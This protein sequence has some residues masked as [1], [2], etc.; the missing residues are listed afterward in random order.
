MK[1]DR[2]LCSVCNKP[3]SIF[4]CRGCQKDF[5]TVHAKEHRQDLSKQ[6]DGIVLE[7]DQLKQNLAQYREKSDQHPLMQKIDQWE[8]ESLEKIRKVAEDARKRLRDAITGH[9]TKITEDVKALTQDLTTARSEDSFIEI[10]LKSW[11]EKLEK[12]TKDLLTPSS[13]NVQEEISDTPFIQKLVVMTSESEFFERSAGKVKINDN[14]QVVIAEAG[15]ASTVRCRGEYSLGQHQFR[16]QLEQKSAS[17]WMFFGI[18]S[19]NTPMQEISYTT[20]TTFG[21]ITNNYVIRCDPG[22]KGYNGYQS[23][24]EQNDTIELSID[25]NRHTISL[26]NI[27]TNKKHELDV[28]LTKCPFP[29]QLHFGLHYENDR[30]RCLKS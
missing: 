11:M 22:Q 12:C 20:P 13:I 7:H 10:D 15:G 2:S 5:C 23:D 25:C 9:I 1:A 30:I 29:W 6:L 14:G 26:T 28:D 8:T 18:V 16:F 27:R 19:K 24:M 21:W 4:L 3:T 17:N